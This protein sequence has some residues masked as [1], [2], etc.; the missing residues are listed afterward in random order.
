MLLTLYYMAATWFQA[1]RLSAIRAKVNEIIAHGAGLVLYHEPDVSA[2]VQQGGSTRIWSQ[3]LRGISST[4]CENENE[5]RV[6]DLLWYHDSKRACSILPQQFID[7]SPWIAFPNESTR[8]P[9][10]SSKKNSPPLIAESRI[11]VLIEA[12][13]R[14]L[15]DCTK[16]HHCEL[17]QFGICQAW[18][19]ADTF[20]LIL[21]TDIEHLIS[22]CGCFMVDRLAFHQ[23]LEMT[24]IQTIV[25]KGEPC[26][27]YEYPQSLRGSE[28]QDSATGISFMEQLQY[29]TSAAQDA[30]VNGYQ[31]PVNG[32][33]EVL[34]VAGSSDSLSNIPDVEDETDAF[35]DEASQLQAESCNSK[36]MSRLE[37]PHVHIA[38]AGGRSS[39]SFCS[40]D[41]LSGT[42]SCLAISPKPSPARSNFSAAYSTL[43]L[44]SISSTISK[45]PNVLI[46]SDSTVAQDNVL[47]VLKNTLHRYKYVIYSMTRQSLSSNPWMQGTR[48]LV[49]C[50][51]VPDSLAPMF[52]SYV[53][54]GGRILCLCSDFLHLVLPTFRTAEVRQHELVRFS[55]SRWKNVP[56]MHHVFCYQASPVHTRFPVGDP[57]SSTC[58]NIGSGKPP[59]TPATVEVLDSENRLHT[60]Q[61]QVLGTEETWQTPSLL[62]ASTGFGPGAGKIVFSQVHLEEDPSQ[63]ESEEG[64]YSTLRQSDGAR[65]EILRDLLVSHLDMECG[66]S[67]RASNNQF[68]QGYFLGRHELKQEFLSSLRSRMNGNILKNGDLELQFCGKGEKPTTASER[69]FPILL[70]SCPPSFSTVE[71]FDN[72]RTDWLG[73]LVIYSEAMGSSM[74]VTGYEQLWH[75][76]AIIPRQQLT[77]RGRGSNM[78]I[79]PEG[80]AMSTVQLIV[81]LSSPLGQ[82]ASLIQHVVATAV[83]SALTNLPDVGKALDLHLKWPNDIYICCDN[84]LIKIGGLV[85]SCTNRGTNLICNIG[86]AVNLDNRDPTT[87]INEQIMLYNARSGGKVPTLSLEKWLAI[88]FTELERL[89]S[90]MQNYSEA[91][92]M[93]L[94]YKF[95]LHSDAEIVVRD[96]SGNEKQVVIQGVDEF[97]FLLVREKNGKTFTVQ[98]DGNTFDMCVG[99]IAPK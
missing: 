28:D 92:V 83:V 20:G 35:P 33:K 77:G 63:Y 76:L 8:F 47:N 43:S 2:A 62:L 57:K 87:C 59:A 72:L 93:D 26:R 79:S 88:F 11:H 41:S 81:P 5:A 89:L 73:R 91:Q 45:P 10:Q 13:Y 18:L 69:L 21:E 96:T 23:N 54:N 49:I 70:H 55:Y 61:V 3:F 60:L 66:D 31:V 37:E 82:R 64:K 38:S 84:D 15:L 74:N 1:W 25:A 46:Y 4:L 71:Y 22:L 40:Q 85:L 78:W 7:L 6:V 53:L 51:S 42:L 68:T 48:L 99:L 65:R 14:S 75:G 29:I 97:G 50:G 32:Q 16:V 95:W 27:M 9:I 67:A 17:E 52:L 30:S 34:V 24:R 56:M 90:L 44:S 58:G 19:A 12:E 86:L 36:H 39:D 80:C 94:Y 98:P